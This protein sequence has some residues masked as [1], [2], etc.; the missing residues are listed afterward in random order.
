[1]I[2]EHIS[3]LKNNDA[4]SIALFLLYTLT[5]IPEYTTL[6]ELP[7][8]LEKDSMLNLLKYYGGNTIRIPTLDE[9]SGILKLT[10]LY[11]ETNINERTLKE[12]SKL[13]NINI[14]DEKTLLAYRKICEVLDGYEFKH[15]ESYN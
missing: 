6:C 9:L 11:I 8:I 3:K 1:M 5:Q 4:Y 2:K 15:R 12:T 13:F 14:D 10:Q 7:Y